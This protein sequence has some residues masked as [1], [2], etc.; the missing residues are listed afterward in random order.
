MKWWNPRFE[1]LV[2]VLCGG[3]LLAFEHAML[4]FAYGIDCPP[5]VFWRRVFSEAVSLDW[6][7]YVGFPGLVGTGFVLSGLYWAWSREKSVRA[8]VWY[9]LVCLAFGVLAFALGAFYVSFG[10][11][12][13]G[14]YLIAYLAIDVPRYFRGLSGSSVTSPP[15]S[16]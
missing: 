1:G 16:P 3:V 12:M 14:T 4:R 11:M 13:L 5:L 10:L 7:Q 6:W 15:S 9:L 8:N 2:L